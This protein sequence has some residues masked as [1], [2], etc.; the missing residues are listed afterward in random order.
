MHSAGILS[1]EG[2]GLVD[3]GQKKLVERR[4]NRGDLSSTRLGK[5][6]PVSTSGVA[7]LFESFPI[8]DAEGITLRQVD[9]SDA[10]D[11][12]A[13]FSL[14][15]VM[16]YYD[17]PPVESL[18]E[19]DEM[20]QR[21]QQRYNDRQAIR[22]GIVREP[23]PNIV[24]TIGLQIYTDWRAALGYD[25]R[26][27]FWRQGVMTRSLSKVIRYAFEEVE[28]QRLEALVIPGN[29]ASERLLDKLGFQREGLLR[30][31]LFV[32]GNHQDLTIFSL[33][34]SRTYL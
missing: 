21:W 28:L 32:N 11:I 34:N 9:A 19:V 6:V 2:C 26:P 29:V 23:D 18:A 16:Q 15:E 22:W 7:R 24:G 20:I 25:L 3:E 30:D 12:F 17:R 14:P 1:S 5:E 13:I 31:Y 33:L 8:L 4:G 27:A 10:D